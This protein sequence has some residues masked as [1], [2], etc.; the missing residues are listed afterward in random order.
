M[1][2]GGGNTKPP[3]PSKK[4]RVSASKRWCFTHN[5]PNEN[6]L[7]EMV[8][9]FTRLGFDYVIGR[10]VGEGGTPHLQG[11][12]RS[13]YVFRPMETLRLDFF[14]HWE[15]CK[16]DHD[17]NV[18]YCTKD[19]DYVTN[20]DIKKPPIDMDVDKDDIIP[21]DDMFP[22]GRALVE[23]VSPGLPNK[24]D[25]SIHWFWSKEGQMQKTE[26][27]RYLCFYHNAVCIQGGRKHVLAVAYKN[28]APIYI[29]LVPRTDEGFVSYASLELLKDSLYMSAFGTEATGM[30]NRKKPWVIVMANFSPDQRALSHDR[31]QITNVDVNKPEDDMEH[32]RLR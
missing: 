25:R 2:E 3:P 1:V 29:L 4:Q 11:Y 30:V 5:N 26:V 24:L 13:S 19:G 15:K 14:P 7:V 22:W 6:D 10:E 8:E 20:L 18:A 31:W 28:P 32:F 27:S 12:V 16:G 21:W 17:A 23:M 9:M